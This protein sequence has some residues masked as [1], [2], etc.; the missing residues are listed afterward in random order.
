MPADERKY[1]RFSQHAYAHCTFL[2]SSGYVLSI[3]AHRSKKLK[4]K[5]RHKRKWITPI[6]NIWKRDHM[7]GRECPSKKGF[8]A[9]S[10]LFCFCDFNGRCSD[11][12]ESSW[13]LS[14]GSKPRLWTLPSTH[15]LD[16]GYGSVHP[17][18]TRRSGWSGH[19]HCTTNRLSGSGHSYLERK[20][21]LFSQ[22]NSVSSPNTN[23]NINLSTFGLVLCSSMPASSS[24]ICIVH[25]VAFRATLCFW[26]SWVRSIK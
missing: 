5:P 13:T 19:R 9:I 11:W 17:G 6:L 7:G 26:S 14:W 20:N 4:K 1:Y 2:L 3:K 23:F 24:K 25:F 16:S 12:D 18:T 22:C 8:I 15:H 10:F 21:D